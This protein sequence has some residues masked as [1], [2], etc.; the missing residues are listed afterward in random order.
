MALTD[1]EMILRLCIAALL[2]GLIGYER[3]IHERPAGFRTHILVGVGSTLIMLT[4]MHIFDI[5]KGVAVPDPGRIAA[6]VVS[7]I[8]FLGAGTIIRFKASVRGLT[9]AA[10]LWTVAGIGLAVGAG[11]FVPAAATTAIVLAALFFLNRVEKVM[12][13]REWYK[14]LEI[15]AKSGTAELEQIRGILLEYDVEIKDF[16]VKKSPCSDGVMLRIRVKL[17]SGEF[18]SEILSKIRQVSGVSKAEWKV[19]PEV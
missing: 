5:Y 15:E 10:S 7:G 14:S 9:T 12:I 17:L 1:Y 3:E 8:G 4:S 6:Q 18:D 2:S 19:M 16:D 13:R 11:L